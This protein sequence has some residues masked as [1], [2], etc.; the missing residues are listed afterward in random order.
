MLF[1]ADGIDLDVAL[2]GAVVLV[3]GGH[4][5][6]AD[7]A[8][9]LHAQ[10]VD[11]AAAGE[12][13]VLPGI[14]CRGCDVVIGRSIGGSARGGNGRG[15]DRPTMTSAASGGRARVANIQRQRVEERTA[16]AVGPHAHR[17]AGGG[18]HH[19]GIIGNVGGTT[20][21][22]WF[23]WRSRAA[24]RHM[25]QVKVGWEDNDFREENETREEQV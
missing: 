9:V 14:G 21:M 23:R 10:D 24:V 4:G 6:P 16:D 19:D 22:C 5:Q 11:G 3:A 18:R 12:E 7:D 15:D 1:W 8:A 2:V 25:R 20:S 13:E 17:R